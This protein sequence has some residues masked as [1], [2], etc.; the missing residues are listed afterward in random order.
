VDF[1]SQILQE[2]PYLSRK[3]YF[4][5]VI[6][7]IGAALLFASVN[8]GVVQQRSLTAPQVVENINTITSL[9]ENL[10]VPANNINF[11]SGV[12][13]LLGLGPFP[14]SMPWSHVSTLFLTKLETGNYCGI[15]HYYPKC[16]R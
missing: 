1:R 16:K 6:A 9:S 15:H 11:L 12:L 5:K 2:E 10:Q 7:V 4:T 14:V 8:A 13:L 3:M